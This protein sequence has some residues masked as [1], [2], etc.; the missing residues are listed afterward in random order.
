MN[1]VPT[2]DR[3]VIKRDE[4]EKKTAGG[5]ILTKDAQKE[6]NYG[7][8]VAVGPGAWDNGQRRPVRLSAGQRVLFTDYHTT[9]CGPNLVIADEED[10]L[11]V[12]EE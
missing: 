2:Q 5:S 4:V 7:T 10:I 6:S 11:A 3:V 1:V 12:I 8:I 9:G